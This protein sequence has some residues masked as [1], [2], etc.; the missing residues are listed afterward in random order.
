MGSSPAGCNQESDLPLNKDTFETIILP[1]LAAT[2]ESGRLVPFIGSGMSVPV[3]TDWWEFIRRLEVAATRKEVRPLAKDIQRDELIRR[4]NEAVRSLKARQTGAFESAVKKALLRGTGTPSLP[5]Q[6]L[7]L[8]K[9]R[10][11]LVLSTNY[12]NCYPAALR[13]EAPDRPLAVVGRGLE[14]CQRVL[15]SLS[16]AGRSLLWALQGYLDAPYPVSPT[17]RHFDTSWSLDT[18]NTAL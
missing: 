10:W 11:S 12:D 1:R 7:A 6:T 2:Y 18:R 9:L 8:A 17:A 15:N 16:V 14:D 13:Q 5:A 3:C 4:A